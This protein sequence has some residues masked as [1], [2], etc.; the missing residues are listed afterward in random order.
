MLK[1]AERTLGPLGARV[2]L[3]HGY[4]DDAPDGPFD[5]ATCLLT[6]HF[7]DCR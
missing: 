7:L 5:A 1:L 4:I 2:Q 3:Q 6:L